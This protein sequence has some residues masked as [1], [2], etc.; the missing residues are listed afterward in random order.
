[1]AELITD[2]GAR[3]HLLEAIGR[4]TKD[5]A[6]AE[7]S[8]LTT[9]SVNFHFYEDVILR[10]FLRAGCRLNVLMVDAGQTAAAMADPYLRPRRAGQDYILAP[11]KAPGAFHPK[12]LTLMAKKRSLIAIGSNNATDSGFAK[13]LEVTTC[14]GHDGAD[15]P[16]D[17]MVDAID[18]VAAWLTTS[19]GLDPT[20]AAE[21]CDRLR[22]LCP[23]GGSSG[24][25][26]F[27]GWRPGAQ[28]LLDQLKTMVRGTAKRVSVV[29]P[30]FDHGLHLVRAVATTWRSAELIAAVQPA[31]VSLPSLAGAPDDLRIVDASNLPALQPKVDKSRN[32]AA[33]YLHAKV[34]AVETNEGLWL[35]LGSA[36]PSAP[37]WLQDEAGNAEAIVVLSG[38]TAMET[39]E[40]LGLA[41]LRLAPRLTPEELQAMAV[42]AAGSAKESEAIPGKV[43]MAMV[44]DDRILLAGIDAATCR[45][46]IDLGNEEHELPAT[47][48]AGPGGAEMV[49]TSNHSPIIRIDGDDGP[50][51][52]VI[53]HS[54]P[55]F[56]AAARPHTSARVLDRLGSLD[57][58]DTDLDG[59][60]EALERYIF[61]EGATKAPA[62]RTRG[63][64]TASDGGSDAPFGP[65][66]VSMAN[67]ATTVHRSSHIVEFELAEIISLLIRDLTEVKVGDGDRRVLD[68]DDADGAPIAED[69]E[70]VQQPE[71]QVDWDRL[72]TACRK[73]VSSLLNRLR[74]KMAERIDGPARAAWLFGRLLL[75]LTL[76]RNLRNRRPL[77]QPGQRRGRPES[78]VSLTQVRIAYKSAMAALYRPQDGIAAQLERSAD[79]CL[80]SDRVTLDA[81]LLWAAMEIGADADA[82]PSFGEDREEKARRL[83]DKADTI[84]AAMSAAAHPGVAGSPLARAPAQAWKDSVGLTGPDWWQRHLEIGAALQAA[85][86]ENGWLP[87]LKRPPREGDIVIWMQE[88]GF[89]RVVAAASGN[90]VFLF[91]P[92]VEDKKGYHRLAM[93]AV[94]PVDGQQLRPT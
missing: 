39:Y 49:I 75:V 59:I 51:T 83:S 17:V 14:W 60:I 69:V 84:V 34:L 27:L 89:P 37:A 26:R 81:L 16:G 63:T 43:Q 68:A 3:L 74:A 7:A 76:L 72:V 28:S 73:R 71:R 66:G 6:R 42:R 29:G 8:V 54:V 19:P 67:L 38:D 12:I 82:T 52:T 90:K 30:F 40:R 45:R 24:D 55:Q 4:L 77:S 18:F 33:G 36:N 61:T 1:M 93:V 32:R 10:Q 25:A 53:L 64:T 21:I 11:I 87:T 58:M 46:A 79:Y 20:L 56:R 85:A 44:A 92:G 78:L 50:L 13:N 15:V 35:A 23:D 57:A 65:R 80:A 62:G 94:T 5:G 91:S 31:T 47:F 88:P 70:S 41:W 86:Q 2:D 9:F 22:Y 48:L